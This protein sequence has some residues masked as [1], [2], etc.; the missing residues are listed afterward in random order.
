M[1]SPC[2]SC[3]KIDDRTR[4]VEIPLGALQ[5]NIS[6]HT[7]FENPGPVEIEIGCGKG[8][9]IIAA[10]QQNPHINYFGIERAGKFFRLLRHRV[11]KA[12][13]NNVRLLRWDALA[14]MEKYVPPESVHAYHVYFPDPWPKKRHRKRRL[15]S[16]S[17]VAAVTET[18]VP[19][20]FLYYGTD[21]KEYFEH[22]LSVTGTAP[23]LR[24]RSRQTIDPEEVDAERA[25]TSYE[26]KYLLQGRPVYR[27]S[28][29]KTAPSGAQP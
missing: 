13:L 5:S 27:A 26:R 6:W 29:K 9:F 28:F 23:G 16:A 22:M 21:Y 15:V 20:G 4:S 3:E 17:F 19:E 2:R 12:A 11:E 18:L 25:L 10:A 8:R 24:E 7:L 14:F 1:V